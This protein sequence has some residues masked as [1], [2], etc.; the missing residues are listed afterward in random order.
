MRYADSDLLD[1]IAREYV[2]GT[3]R[4]RAR[5]RFETVLRSNET[6][7]VLVRSWEDRLLPLSLELAPVRPQASAWRAVESRLDR[8]ARGR[9]GAGAAVGGTLQRFR[10]AIAA[11]IALVSLGIGWLLVTRTGEP[12][13]VAVLAPEGQTAIWNVET[14][15]ERGRIRIVVAG[16][17][18]AQPGKSYELWALPEGR[19]PVSLGLMPARN[20]TRRLDAAQL[21]ALA[22]SK[23]VAVSLEP[24]GGSPT[25]APTG[26][27]LYVGTIAPPA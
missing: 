19:A 27:V 4:G 26:P 12:T 17:I 22:A 14:F 25:G 23:Q 13:A 6:A 8:E 21:A 10:F 3:L 2:V 7:R 20:E 11:M 18:P 9:G 15:P 1:R 16:A 5:A 24:P